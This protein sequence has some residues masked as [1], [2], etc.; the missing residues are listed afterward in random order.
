MR[1]TLAVCVSAL[2]LTGGALATAG[3]AAAG[4]EVPT[5]VCDVYELIGVENVKE[6][7]GPVS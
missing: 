6:C 2:A 1:R 3:P 4:P 5:S 7:E